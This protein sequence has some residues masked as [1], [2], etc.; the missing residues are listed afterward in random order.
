MSF[1]EHAKNKQEHIFTYSKISVMFFVPDG[2]NR[3][4]T[5]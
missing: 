2:E 1:G 5:L 3:D 4:R